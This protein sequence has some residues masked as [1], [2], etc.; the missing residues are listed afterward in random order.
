MTMIAS[1]RQ[2]ASILDFTHGEKFNSCSRENSKN[3][4]KRLEFST[5]DNFHFSSER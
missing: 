1:N 3:S 2:C 5:I 4:E